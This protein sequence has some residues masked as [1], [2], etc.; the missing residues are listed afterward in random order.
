HADQGPARPSCLPRGARRVREARRILRPDGP[1]DVHARVMKIRQRISAA[2]KALRGRAPRR[3]GIWDGAQSNRL[4]QDWVATALPADEE[5]RWSIRRLRDRSREL[6]RN[7]PMARR[8]LALL[9]DNVIGPCGVT[10]QAQVK[11]NNDRVNDL[12]NQRIES[13]WQEWSERPTVDGRLSRVRLEQQLL[14]T[15]ARDGEAFV[16]LWRGY[17]DN[18]FAFALEPIDADMLDEEY[19]VA[20]GDNRNEVRMG[21]ELDRK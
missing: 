17:K 6:A 5:L 8:Y 16:R 13:A 1:P 21:V 15:V 11:N 18:R 3:Y 9:A 4:F 7:N 19:N 14:K 2:W 20:P 12:F 10:L